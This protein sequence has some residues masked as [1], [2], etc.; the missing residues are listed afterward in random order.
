MRVM[1]LMLALVVAALGAVPQ[2][3]LCIAEHH[4]S[5]V[6]FGHTHDHHLDGDAIPH[7]DDEPVLCGHEID[8]D[9]CGEGGCLDVRLGVAGITSDNAAAMVPAPGLSFDRPAPKLALSRVPVEVGARPPHSMDD[10]CLGTCS[11]LL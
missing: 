11:F 2:A 1:V 8:H 9:S 10:I 3:A 4:E 6:V 7:D 5:H